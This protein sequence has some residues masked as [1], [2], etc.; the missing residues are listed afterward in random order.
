MIFLE[1]V[2]TPSLRNR[3]TERRSRANRVFSA[4]YA[5]IKVASFRESRELV[6]AQAQPPIALAI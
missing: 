6:P 3:R 1:G 2:A 5:G 4:R